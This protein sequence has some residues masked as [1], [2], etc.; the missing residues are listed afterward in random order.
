M[1]IIDSVLKVLTNK[2][3]YHIVYL[4]DLLLIELVFVKSIQRK[5]GPFAS[6][7]KMQ[8]LTVLATDFMVSFLICAIEKLNSFCSIL[9]N[10]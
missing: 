10:N 2:G 9:F 1:L 4:L 5:L 3:P 7:Y 8:Q 6:T